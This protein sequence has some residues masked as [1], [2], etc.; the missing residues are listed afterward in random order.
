MLTHNYVFTLP[1]PPKIQWN[2]R[3]IGAC[4][5]TLANYSEG[6]SCWGALVAIFYALYV[7]LESF[8]HP[9]ASALIVRPRSTTAY[10]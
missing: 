6:V 1:A 8:I 7:I 2:Q 5:L 10:S 3:Q 9:F 4:M